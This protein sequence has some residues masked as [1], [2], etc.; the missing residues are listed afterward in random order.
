[1]CITFHNKKVLKIKKEEYSKFKI[2]KH[3]VVEEYV[4]QTL[5]IQMQLVVSILVPQNVI[6]IDF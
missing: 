6:L 3:C 1:M 4:D 2:T 5:F